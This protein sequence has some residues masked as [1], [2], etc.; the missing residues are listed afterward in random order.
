MNSIQYL[1]TLKASK[2][3]TSHYVNQYD[4][5]CT[6]GGGFFK[7]IQNNNA[8]VQEIYGFRIIPTT[9]TLGYWERVVEGPWKVEWFG[10]MN[11]AGQGTLASYGFTTTDL[12]TRYNIGGSNVVTTSDTYDTAA[13]KFVFNLMELG[14]TFSVDFQ[15]KEYYIASTCNL[16]RRATTLVVRPFD[17]FE[18]NGNGAQI[19]PHST[20]T[21]VAFDLFSRVISSQIDANA[22]VTTKFKIDS[23]LFKGDLFSP[24]HT[25]LHLKC[26]YNSELSNLVFSS[27]A[28]GLH[29]RFC[30]NA[31][32]TEVLVDAVTTQGIVV[33]SGEGA[34]PGT[35]YV[36]NNSASKDVELK[37]CR[38]T[39][40]SA[41]LICIRINGAS[42]VHVNQPSFISGGSMGRG[43]WY[44]SKNA[45]AIKDLTITKP[46]INVLFADEAIYLEPS[47]GSQIEIS[48]LDCPYTG[49]VIRCNTS[50]YTHTTLSNLIVRNLSY[51][52]PSSQFQDTG[53]STQWIFEYSRV[54]PTALGRWVAAAMPIIGTW[55]ATP[56][57]NPNAR[58]FDVYPFPV[59]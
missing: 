7:W 31:L 34:W 57:A 17:I 49:R 23:L 46:H 8:G 25:G 30:Q 44:D 14:Y 20:V 21:S 11:I 2:A 6:A 47:S 51:L 45:P 38:F 35:F 29:L 55:S 33:D 36:T 5:N 22:Q 19:N 26:T 3:Y 54:D 27:L 56:N 13:I 43:I 40:S 41:A 24:I 10:V 32:V 53:G 12:N 39:G 16:P 9:T 15:S 42:G 37:K 50:I 4:E 18:I 48:E 58:L 59:R 1:S 52:N 28:T